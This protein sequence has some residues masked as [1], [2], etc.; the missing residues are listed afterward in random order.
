MSE[1]IITKKDVEYVAKLARLA[2]TEDEKARYEG[3]LERILEYVS[4]L[5]KINTDDVAPTAH[6]FEI[7]NVT[8]PDVPVTFPDIPALFKNAPEVEESFY[9]VKKVIEES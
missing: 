3:Q 4:Q 5:K 2:I 1:K 7:S 8:R 6:P 9:R